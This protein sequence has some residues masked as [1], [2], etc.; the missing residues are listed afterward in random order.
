MG[1][2]RD[3]APADPVQGALGALDRFIESWNSRDP[4]RFAQAMHYPHVRVAPRGEPVVSADA[5]AYAAEV[6]YD[7]ALAMGWDHSR[8]D[9]KRVIQVSADRVHAAGRWC[10]YDA[11]GRR[12]LPNQVLYVVTRRGDDWRIQARFGI[13]S[14]GTPQS[15]GPEAA[16]RFLEALAA[17]DRAGVARSAHFPLIEVDGTAVR[18]HPDAESAVRALCGLALAGSE[19]IQSGQ[20]GLG[21]ALELRLPSG[22]GAA[23]VCLVIRRDDRWGVRAL[24]LLASAPGG[25]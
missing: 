13:D 4:Y 14:E 17:E 19:T 21:L 2:E 8:W 6:R 7:Q 25:S 11:Q 22:A 12:L 10:R 1:R 24:S 20:L 3:G 23:G 15:G 18:S 16:G 9:E 5:A